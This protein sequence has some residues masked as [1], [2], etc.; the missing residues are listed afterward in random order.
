MD[1][2]IS[3]TKGYFKWPR[4][5]DFLSVWTHA[6][7][8]NCNDNNST[9]NQAEANFRIR[10]ASGQ[11]YKKIIVNVEKGIVIDH[12]IKS[13]VFLGMCT[14][15]KWEYC[16]SLHKVTSFTNIKNNIIS[17]GQEKDISIINEVRMK[18]LSNIW[19]SITNEVISSNH[20][21]QYILILCSKFQRKIKVQ[22]PCS[23]ANYAKNSQS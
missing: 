6:R 11:G 16:V 20:T 9:T 8:E 15:Y 13:C 21:I 23:S 1:L 10:G 18:S 19:L 2:V 3:E 4:P 12:R 7:C 5:P 17:V 22:N 14:C